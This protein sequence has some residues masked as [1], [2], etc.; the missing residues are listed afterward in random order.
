MTKKAKQERGWYGDKYWRTYLRWDPDSWDSSRWGEP[1]PFIP[2]VRPNMK[3][4]G[5]PRQMNSSAMMAEEA[6]RTNAHEGS[7]DSTGANRLDIYE[8]W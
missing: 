7:A 1:S 5:T 6:S 4:G 2:E 8:I 3:D